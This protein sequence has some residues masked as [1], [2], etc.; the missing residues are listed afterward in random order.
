MLGQICNFKPFAKSVP[1][2]VVVAAGKYIG[3]DSLAL[4]LKL[5][6]ES[7]VFVNLGL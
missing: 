4:V 3:Q 1:N 2:V 6:K 7:L 5:E